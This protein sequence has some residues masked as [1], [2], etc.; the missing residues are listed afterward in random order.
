MSKI[1]EKLKDNSMLFPNKTA[2]I[3]GDGVYLTYA[4]LVRQVNRKIT[5]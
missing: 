2:V 3:Q 4:Q 5:F 1:F